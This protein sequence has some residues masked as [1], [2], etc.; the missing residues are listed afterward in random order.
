MNQKSC[1]SAPGSLM[2]FGE[3]AVLRGHPAVVLPVNYRLAVALER[4]DEALIEI[5]SQDYGQISVPVA[6]LSQT[7]LQ[8]KGWE[9]HILHTL[10]VWGIN[11]GLKVTVTSEIP[12]FGLGSSAALVAALGAALADMR[13]E[14]L[15]FEQ[16]HDRGYQAIVNA[17]GGT[18]LSGADLAASLW[19]E[20]LLY[21]VAERGQMASRRV[22]PLKLSKPL[23]MTAIY[24][25]HKGP[26]PQ[27]VKL[28]D[29]AAEAFPTFY[30]PVFEA[31]G[32]LAFQAAEALER[33][34]EEFVGQ[35]MISA[36][37]LMAAIHLTSPHID[38]L[39]MFCLTQDVCQGVKISG[40]GLGDC[41]IAL[42]ALSDDLFE[43]FPEVL[44]VLPITVAKTGVA[45]GTP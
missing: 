24:S 38:M 19:G 14:K 16:L 28:V 29:E 40:S 21:T 6:N 7:Q 41:L 45:V 34:A 20:C 27:I 8:V 44:D 26:T 30:G 2:L 10:R 12:P 42:G 39:Q 35:V 36:H 23:P 15:T 32:A 33:G 4:T 5:F 37:H 11:H 18:T 9:G 1:A 3:H 31:M 13:G 25:G 22:K 43:M 17:N